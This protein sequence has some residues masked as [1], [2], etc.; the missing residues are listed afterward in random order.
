MQYY[1]GNLAIDERKTKQVA[2]PVHRQQPPVRQPATNPAPQLP[3]GAKLLRLA[4][5]IF[6]VC[7]L[8]FIMWR[9]TQIYQMN[10]DIRK[11]NAEINELQAENSS[12]KQQIE[13][14]QSPDRLKL[15]AEEYGFRPL[16]QEQIS[17]VSV[18]N[19]AG[20]GSPDQGVAGLR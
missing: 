18:L 8:V 7:V 6:A 12:L 17:R 15:K 9:Y 20:S 1:Q 14:L 10:L 16:D 5:V 13:V 19:K 2:Q 4:A 11:I 3:V